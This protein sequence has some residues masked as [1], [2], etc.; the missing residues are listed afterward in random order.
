[1]RVGTKN[2]QLQ[3]AEAC[4]QHLRE[5]YSGQRALVEEFIEELEGRESDHTRWTQFADAKRSQV[6]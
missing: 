2:R 6:E 1:M 4:K 3:N 5:K